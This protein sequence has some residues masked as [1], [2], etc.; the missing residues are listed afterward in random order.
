[1]ATKAQKKCCFSI[2]SSTVPVSFWLDLL[3]LKVVTNACV[4]ACKHHHPMS[5]S[6]LSCSCFILVR[7]KNFFN[8]LSAPKFWKVEGWWVPLVPT[9][10]KVGTLSQS[11]V[12]EATRVVASDIM[13][14]NIKKI[15]K[16]KAFHLVNKNCI[17]CFLLHWGGVGC[18]L[19]NMKKYI[20]GTILQIRGQE[21]TSSYYILF[22][23]MIRNL[24]TSTWNK[25]VGKNYY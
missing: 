18:E 13:Q 22:T 14:V 21:L 9:L 23:Q 7:S 11:Y 17:G 24:H 20:I 16:K 10:F 5:Q 2:S 1:M 3:F 25:V 12:F 8:L 4:H 6:I 19:R 15:H